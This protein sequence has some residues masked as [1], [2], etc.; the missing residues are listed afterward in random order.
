MS[1]Q[2]RVTAIINAI[3]TDANLIILIRALIT[4]NLPNALTQQLINAQT[5]LE[6]PTQ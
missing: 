6:L 2:D 4:N 1:D 5:V 3:Q